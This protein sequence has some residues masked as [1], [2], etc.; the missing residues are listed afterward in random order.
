[1]KLIGSLTSP[2]VRKIR[3]ALMEKNIPFD[4]IIDLPMDP[5]TRVPDFNPL[6][7]IPVLIGDDKSIWYESDLIIEYIETL[8]ADLPLMPQDRRA[9]L[10][11]RRSLMLADGTTDA[12]VLIFLEK[13]RNADKQ[14]PAWIDWQRGKVERG[15]AAL[16][17]ALLNKTFLHDDAFGVADI[18][19]GCLLQWLEFRLPEVD[20][21]EKYP[22]LA[23]LNTRLSARSSFMRTIPESSPSIKTPLPERADPK[24]RAT[25]KP[26]AKRAPKKT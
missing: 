15:L 10:P 6:G 17:N 9:A 24:P 23:A 19:V 21:L 4:L 22:S 18:A 13:R 7:K 12:G 16:E 1:M 25:V 8:H 11:V 14:D 26:R 20:W 3:I 5:H 2:F